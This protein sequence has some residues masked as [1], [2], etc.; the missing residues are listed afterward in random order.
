MCRI[1]EDE[2]CLNCDPNPDNIDFDH[3]GCRYCGDIDCTGSCALSDYDFEGD[4]FVCS[5]CNG[6]GCM[7]CEYDE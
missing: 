1:C 4:D 7:R 6:G 2:G 3:G 5:T